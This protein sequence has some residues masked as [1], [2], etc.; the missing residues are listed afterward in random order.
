MSILK[1]T[2]M[3]AQIWTIENCPFCV[4]A[5]KLMKLKEI[6]Y[7]ERSGFHPDWP[8]VPYIIVDGEPIGGFQELR[9]KLYSN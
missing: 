3:Q 7:E 9:Q 1:K 8:S 6:K 4:K 2:N 5:K